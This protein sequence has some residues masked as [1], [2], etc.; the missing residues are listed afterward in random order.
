MDYLRSASD[1]V[2][3]TPLVFVGGAAAGYFMEDQICSWMRAH[4]FI[5]AG[6]AGLAAV[7]V[8]TVVVKAR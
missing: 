7:G 2:T 5:T 1:A 3:T 6:V 8:Y 4:P